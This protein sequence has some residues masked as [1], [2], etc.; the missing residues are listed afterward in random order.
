MRTAISISSL[1]SVFTEY[2]AISYC[3]A[4]YIIPRTEITLDS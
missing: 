3:E 4:I 1:R 2:R